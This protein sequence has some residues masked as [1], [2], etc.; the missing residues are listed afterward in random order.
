VEVV[1]H[2]NC[3]H[4]LTSHNASFRLELP[5]RCKTHQMIKRLGCENLALR[6]K[7]QFLHVRPPHAESPPGKA[8]DHVEF[9]ITAWLICDAQ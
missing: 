2:S 1:G 8:S 9:P 4:W 5:E 6:G 7:K 3:P